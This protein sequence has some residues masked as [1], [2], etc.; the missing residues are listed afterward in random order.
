MSKKPTLSEGII[1]NGADQPEPSRRPYHHIAKHVLHHSA[2]I[3]GRGLRP[4]V[5]I[6]FILSFLATLFILGT[7]FVAITYITYANDITSKEKIMNRNNLG[8][9]IYDKNNQE[10][11]REGDAH[12]FKLTPL[13]KIS[14]PM[15]NATL[16][17][18]DA[19]FYH[20]PA[21]S[22]GAFFASILANF[23]SHDAYRFGGSTITQ[24]L[25]KSALVGQEKSY[26]RKLKEIILA[27]EIERRYSKNEIMEMYLN[28]IYYG[29]GA[30]GVE[31]AAKVYFN[32]DASQLNLAQASFLAGLPNAPSY[33]T[34]YGGDKNAAIN[35]QK[36]ILSQ[37]VQHGLATQKQADEAGAQKLTFAG[38]TPLS[39][40]S[41][42][43]FALW[44]RNQVFQQYTEDS[45]ERN[46]YK[47][48]TTLDL[49]LQKLAEK[50]VADRVAEL[51]SYKV[52]NGA[53]VAIDP[54]SGGV[55]AMVGSVDYNND[56]VGGKFNIAVDGT[57]RQPGS[58]F[59]PF[60]YA[61]AFDHNLL[62]PASILHDNPTDFG[63]YGGEHFKPK[64][65]DGKYRGDVTVR[66]AL[67]N[68]LN[69]PAVEALK[70]V[71]VDSAID[72][73]QRLGITTF[74]DRSR[75]GLSLVLGGGEVHLLEMVEAYSAFAG[76]GKQYPVYSMNK[77]VDKFG[78]VVYDHTQDGTSAPKD[79]MDPRVAFLIT[80]I[81]SDNNAR[82]E[83]FGGNSPLKLSRPA[84][85]KTGTT[86]DFKDS[87]TMGY[88]PNLVAGAWVGNNNG[89]P[90]TGVAGALGGA[91]V[92]HNFMEQALP[93]F[94]REDFSEPA[95]IVHSKSCKTVETKTTAY[96]PDG[97]PY[98]HY[99]TQTVVTDDVFIQGTEPKQEC[100]PSPSPGTSGS[101]QNNSGNQPSTP[102]PPADQPQTNLP[103]GY[104]VPPGP[105][106]QIL[107][108]R[109][110]VH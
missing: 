8:I 3:A 32:E 93:A 60:V 41:A 51:A 102:N 25:V 53:L 86:D 83:E 77:I 72:T 62:T 10:I 30:Y 100:N 12:N 48:Y 79:V 80:N 89:T 74:N 23:R 28:S 50:A 34:P 107:P 1:S 21:I 67:A 5:R 73:A 18:E 91:Y 42:P 106:I 20:H 27:V 56:A 64:D 17:G 26:S 97:T 40:V 35:R 9:I 37:M 92:W 94:P 58:S 108:D 63:V 49:N 15:I 31:D 59:K 99:D 84:A 2:R 6:H 69:I 95:G 75:F 13:D 70:L 66:R 43:H 68:S 88:T 96:L 36:Y 105:N 47:I 4:F 22:F 82:S 101:D 90:M 57:G 24:Q 7:I 19:E 110:V 54:K 85:A 76:G 109:V 98:D 103:P 39:L 81:L 14:K 38:Y 55:L 71:G 45:A 65:Y 29:A 11:F 44:V 33:L 87:W 104:V 16:A 61:T 52:T 46:G 78:N